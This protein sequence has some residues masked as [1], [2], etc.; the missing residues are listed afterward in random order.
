MSDGSFPKFEVKDMHSLQKKTKDVSREYFNQTVDVLNKFWQKQWN[1]LS[2]NTHKIIVHLK[3]GGFKKVEKK[4][5][6][7]VGVDER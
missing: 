1:V 6:S 3:L 2:I 7:L 5:K 4:N